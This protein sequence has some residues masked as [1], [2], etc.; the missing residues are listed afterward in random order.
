MYLHMDITQ[1]K[2]NQELSTDIYLF[3][4]INLS[5]WIL[6][7]LHIAYITITFICVI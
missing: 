7:V 2:E 5:L 1:H 4:Y 3:I 6:Y